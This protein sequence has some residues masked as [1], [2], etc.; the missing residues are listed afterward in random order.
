M[1][2]AGFRQR[3]PLLDAAAEPN[4][5]AL[6]KVAVERDYPAE[7]AVL[8]EDAWGNAVYFIV[9]GLVRVRLLRK[10]SASTLAVLGRGEF[11]GEMA[12]LDEAPRS[13]DVVAIAP[14]KL[15]TIPAKGFV[16]FLMGD[17]KAH[18]RMLQ[19]MVRRL[20]KA[21]QRSQWRQA[22]VGTRIVR[23]VLDAVDSYGEED[24]GVLTLPE[25]PVADIGDLAAATVE[26]VKKVMGALHDKGWLQRE[27]AT[28][29]WRVGDR[30][31]LAKL[32]EGS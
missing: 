12:V 31:R 16:D 11:F 32:V 10:D 23:V 13:T 5:E 1:N 27:A 9:E 30:A 26:E 21:N 3:F 25:L 18:Y 22:P 17:A 2:T 6:L 20:R 8:M 29:Q 19:L 4:L 15:L 24:N 7:R 28:R 14:V